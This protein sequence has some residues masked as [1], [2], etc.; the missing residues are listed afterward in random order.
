MTGP[1]AGVAD[2]P[3]TDAVRESVEQLAVKRLA[4]QL[5]VDVAGVFSGKPVIVPGYHGGLHFLRS[6]SG[7]MPRRYIFL[8]R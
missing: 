4:R 3:R 6:R 7:D 8:G 5:A 1:A 2:A